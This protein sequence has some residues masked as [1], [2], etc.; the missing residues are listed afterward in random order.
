M[1]LLVIIRSGDEQD[2]EDDD[3]DQARRI[4]LLC[5]GVMSDD[6][7]DARGG[8]FPDEG[9]DHIVPQ[10]Q[11]GQ[12]PDRIEERR[13]DIGY[14]TRDE[15]DREPVLAAVFINGIQ[16]F[17]LADDFLRCLAEEEAQQQEADGDADGL[18][19]AGQD[20]ARHD[21]ED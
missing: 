9:G 2:G 21:P 3:N 1:F 7:L 6:C 19:H 13:G 5:D 14:H 16:I 12:R 11:R 18:G 4:L 15:H 20:D 8:K 10:A 17:A